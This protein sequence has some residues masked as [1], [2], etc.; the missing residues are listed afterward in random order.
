[1]PARRQMVRELV[2]DTACTILYLQESKLEIVNSNVASE[3][4]EDRLQGMIY[5]PAD[6]TRGAL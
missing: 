1:M 5:K 6:G 3:I 2:T 4:T